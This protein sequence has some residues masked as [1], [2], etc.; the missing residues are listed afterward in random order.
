MRPAAEEF[1]AGHPDE[2]RL[3]ETSVPHMPPHEG[4]RR[5]PP[6]LRSDPFALFQMALYLAHR[7]ATG[8]QG[9]NLVVESRPTG[10]MLGDELQ[11]IVILKFLHRIKWRRQHEATALNNPLSL[12]VRVLYAQE[13][14]RINADLP[15]IVPS[16]APNKTRSRYPY[17]QWQMMQ[18]ELTCDKPGL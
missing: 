8:V 16:T 14:R 5:V 17:I 9:Q 2:I 3:G 4:G 10:W 1:L 12:A 6:L 7:H 15:E 11:N 18:T 13:V